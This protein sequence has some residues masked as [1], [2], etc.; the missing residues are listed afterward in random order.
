VDKIT[1]I[2]D[3]SSFPKRKYS[4]LGLENFVDS[5]KRRKLAKEEERKHALKEIRAK[6]RAKGVAVITRAAHHADNGRSIKN[7]N[8][9]G[10]EDA[11][12]TKVSLIQ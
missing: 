12:T 11:K 9:E 2:M 10:L 8:E 4:A 5:A 6:R 1:V 3:E 7:L